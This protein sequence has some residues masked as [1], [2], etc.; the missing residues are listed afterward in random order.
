VEVKSSVSPSEDRILA[1]KGK[2]VIIS[3]DHHIARALE[4]VEESYC[5][6][7]Y[8]ATETYVA[9]PSS[10]FYHNG[11]SYGY[12]DPINYAALDPTDD[13]EAWEA[14]YGCMM[15]LDSEEEI[16]EFN[17][18]YGEHVR[19][20]VEEIELHCEIDD[21]HHIHDAN[22]SFCTCLGCSKDAVI[23]H[24]FDAF[25]TPHEQKAFTNHIFECIRTMKER[26]IEIMMEGKR[27]GQGTR[28]RQWQR[29]THVPHKTPSGIVLLSGTGHILHRTLINQG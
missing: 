27:V 6:F 22:T 19:Q 2:P 15:A 17:F 16:A 10:D 1:D 14:V 26:S 20:T 7:G 5:F 12:K 11:I 13:E 24:P 23:D 18:Q 3:S 29:W 8:W 4:K 21:H 25:L 28:I 9:E